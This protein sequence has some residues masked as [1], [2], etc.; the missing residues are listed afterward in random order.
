MLNKINIFKPTLILTLVEAAE[1]NVVLFQLSII[2][3]MSMKT[4]NDT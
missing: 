2:I 3:Y 4:K 1:K